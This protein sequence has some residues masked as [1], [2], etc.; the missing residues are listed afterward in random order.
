MTEDNISEL[1]AKYAELLKKKNAAMSAEF[2]KEE[3]AKE[4]EAK[5]LRDEQTE[6]DFNT[7]LDAAIALR[8]GDKGD[9][10]KPTGEE[11]KNKPVEVKMDKEVAFMKHFAETRGIKSFAAYENI[12]E[13]YVT[14]GTVA[15]TD[16]DSGCEDDVDTWERNDCFASTIWQ[17]VLCK[18]GFAGNITVRG[19]DFK[20]GCGGK[21]QLKVL[22]VASPSSDFGAMSPCACLSCVSNTFSTYTLT[23]EVYGDYKVLCDLD[24]FTAGD[25]V[26]TAVVKSM[27]SR[28]AERID[29][30][31]YTELEANSPTYSETLAAACGGSRGT[32]GE[33]CTYAVD[34]YDSIVD[35]EAD[36]REAGYFSN[37]D[38][39]LILSPTVAAYLKYKD[40]L[41]MPA[42]I[43]SQIRMDG[44]RLAAIGNIRVMESCHANS[45]TDASAEVIGILI[46]PERAIGE[47]WG[48]KPSF[49]VDDDPI[50]CGSQKIV[51]RM[52]ADFSILD[53]AATGH[54]V[55]P[56]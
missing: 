37:A 41:N 15:F 17:S 19:L 16:S 13:Q 21:V 5:K 40:G 39:I 54:V 34:L 27:V 11:D 44:L 20:Q 29:H 2:A 42:Y 6:I 50:E 3:K 56:T 23:M 4:V 14:E 8:L 55:N 53:S 9:G 46:D 26:K 12:A 24:L 47:A 43:A 51:L 18:S 49:K 10:I 38:P 32:D 22:T 28:A 25:S 30:K 31:I 52:W 1:E 36:M 45:C 33:C 7:K 35:L 48:K